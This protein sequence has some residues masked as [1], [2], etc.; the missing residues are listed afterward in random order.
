[1][2]PQK[3][4]TPAAR[5]AQATATKKNVFDYLKLMYGAPEKGMLPA[6]VLRTELEQ[7]FRDAR[8]T[9]PVMIY[10]CECWIDDTPYSNYTVPFLRTVELGIDAFNRFL[11]DQGEET[12][13]HKDIKLATKQ[14][15]S[16]N[17]RCKQMSMDGVP[18]AVVV[19]QPKPWY[20]VIAASCP[21]IEDDRTEDANPIVP[22]LEM[23]TI[24]LD[25][26]RFPLPPSLS[27]FPFCRVLTPAAEKETPEPQLPRRRVYRRSRETQDQVQR[28][29]RRR[30]V[31]TLLQGQ[32]HG[33]L[34]KRNAPPSPHDDLPPLLSPSFC[35]SFL[36]LSFI[37]APQKVA[38]T[39]LFPPRKTKTKKTQTQQRNTA[40]VPCFLLFRRAGCSFRVS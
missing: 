1:M 32:H 17:L 2:L 25:S 14:L 13:P 21:I 20:S 7:F 35:A 33:V 29:S 39:A 3:A 15:P 31:R 16:F 26:V 30:A 8:Y 18:R 6:F 9:V 11:E 4:Q 38:Q 23:H 19:I 5:R 40:S 12:D 24:E 10:A 22:W 36:S 28:P 34:D 27:L 37:L